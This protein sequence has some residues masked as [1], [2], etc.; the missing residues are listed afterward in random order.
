MTERRRWGKAGERLT[1]EQARQRD[2]LALR[3]QA[4]S[5][6][7]RAEDDRIAREKWAA[8]MVV[9]HNITLALDTLGLEGPEV[10]LAC[11]AREPEV[12]MWEA[13]KL[14]PRWDQL[15]AL[16][17]LTERTPRFFVD[18]R[19]RLSIFD[20]S[21]KFHVDPRSLTMRELPV[22]WYPDHV[23]GRCPGTG[24]SGRELPVLVDN[25]G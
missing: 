22:M 3:R 23:V 4:Q 2:A 15:V 14:Y 21:M 7:R 25:E 24:W 8:G 9:P 13:G 16:A 17:E 11:N 18:A 6:E 12:D 10:D 1:P 20:T 19:P 5:A